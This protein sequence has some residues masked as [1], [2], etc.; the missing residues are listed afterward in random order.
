MRSGSRRARAELRLEL[1]HFGWDR[2]LIATARHSSLP[3]HDA[4]APA[5][6]LDAVSLSALTSVGDRDRLSLVAQFAAHQSFLQFAGI[7]DGECDPA[8]WAVAQRRGSDP[9]LLRIAACAQAD[10]SPPVLT[11][12]QQFAEAIGAPRLDVLKQSWGRAEAVYHEVDAR[13]RG[14][15]AAD[16]RWMRRAACGEV[17]APGPDALRMLLGATS[18]RF[19]CSGGIDAVRDAALL[20]LAPRVVTLGGGSPLQRGSALTELIPLIG[21]IEKKSESEIAERVV[22]AMSNARFLFVVPSFDSF[23]ACSRTVVQMLA[24]IDGAVWLIPGSDL[25]EL[26]TFLLSTNLAAR[27]ELRITAAAAE[28]F[29]A[30]REFADYLDHG[31]LPR[32]ESVSPFASIGE[33]KRSWIAALALLGT[34]MPRELASRFLRELFFEEP[35]ETLAIDGVTSVGESFSFAT[36]AIRDDAGRLIP[37][38]SRPSLCRLAADLTDGERAASLLIEAGEGARAT[39]ILEQCEWSSAEETIRALRGLPRP[40]LASSPVLAKRL[41]DVLLQCGRYRDARELAPLLDAP[42]GDLLLARIERRS[43][44][45]APALA[46]LERLSERTFDAQLLLGELLFLEA[47]YDDARAAFAACDQNDE[48]LIYHRA[49]LANE[50]G[51]Y[52]DQ[53]PAGGYF[54]ARFRVYAANDAEEAARHAADAFVLASTLTERIDAALDQVFSNFTAGRWNEAR[55]LAMNALSLV[56]ETQGDRAAGGLLFTL[57][58]LAADDGQWAHAAQRITRLRHFYSGTHDERRLR[59]LELLTAHLDFSR[60]RFDDARRGAGAVLREELLHPQIREAAALIADE[61]D[62]IEG[63]D[64]PLRST[65]KTRNRELTARHVALRDRSATIVDDDDSRSAKLKRFRRALIDGQ[66]DLAAP[67]AKELGITIDLAADAASAELRI[68][69]IAARRPF[70]FDVTDFGALGWRF[71]TRNRLGQWQELGSL[72]ALPSAE[73]DRIAASGETDWIACSDRELLYLSG[74]ERWSADSREAIAALFR[75][76][77]EHHRL[78]R[79]VAQEDAAV[80]ATPPSSIEG[81]VGDSPV[82]RELSHLITRVA[83]RDV[84]ACILGES[85]T[86]KELVARAIHRHSSRRGRPFTP[87]NCAA[88]PEN[89][90][91]SELFGCV[92]GAFTGA[93]RDRAGLIE[94]TDGGTLFLDEIGELPLAAQAKLLRFLQENEFRR[95]GDTQTCTADVRIVT[96]TNRKLETAVEEGRFREDL[97]YRVR[98]IEVSLPPLR[99]RAGDVLLLAATFLA[100]ERERHRGGASKFSQDVEALFASY[101]WPGNVRELQNTIRAAHAMAGDAA[102]T[103]GLAHL[104]ERMRNATIVRASAGSYQDSVARFRREL[105]EKSLGEVNGN[106]N[107]AAAMLKMSRQ[108]L[109]YQIRELGILVHPVRRSEP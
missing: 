86:G 11:S 32:D 100:R 27:R 72:P 84:A 22:A 3:W 102:S 90:I 26:R 15:A 19:G 5:V 105:I 40:L 82:M 23:D 39:T 55:A 42:D 47:R 97:Y 109:A 85:G 66:S 73:L 28:R 35:L 44:D 30:S 70:P 98:G 48:R 58:Y 43:G 103:I 83:S 6:T 106:Q 52:V 96:A 13:L 80:A 49:V 93:D 75:V 54:A 16:L 37:P 104:P 69:R 7:A 8:E 68:L 92:R 56:E 33:P 10:D 50:V 89:L 63:I 88:L 67:L 62:R 12:I 57:A 77:S 24:A 79:I 94:T 2:A 61:I 74:V 20:G 81:I 1:R 60:G 65:G 41:A 36:D 9:R 34:T 25:P 99:E 17:R 21:A 108:A 38:A 46:R 45:Y 71:A 107:R 78:Q 59:E 51:Q 91:E 53:L 29:V 64:A 18:G 4:F 101:S 76:R 95:V 87:V 14:D 31:D